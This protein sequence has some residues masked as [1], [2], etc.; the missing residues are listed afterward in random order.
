MALPLFLLGASIAAFAG[1][2]LSKN[3]ARKS[4]IVGTF[5]GERNVMVKPENGAVVCCGVYELFE[6][7]G[8][9]ADNAIIERN[10]N[11]LVRGVS[12]YRFIQQR[13]GKT[14]YI[15][16]DKYNRPLKDEVAMLRAASQLFQ[17]HRYSVIKNNCN[18]FVAECLSGCDTPITRFSELNS[19]LFQHFSSTIH[20]LKANV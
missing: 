13:S 3:N 15:A 6:H 11:G 8:I 18:R 2:E 14:I 1:N 16:C 12:P 20:W 17:L 7:S 19:L 4:G 5:P 10:G 9:W